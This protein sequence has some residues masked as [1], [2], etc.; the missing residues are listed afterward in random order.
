[1]QLCDVTRSALLLYRTDGIYKP[2][3]PGHPRGGIATY[4]QIFLP[5]QEGD[6]LVRL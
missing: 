1:V 3:F 2:L 5:A 4:E 6:Q